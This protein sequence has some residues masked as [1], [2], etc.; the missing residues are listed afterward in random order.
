MYSVKVI[1]NE[2][3]QMLIAI[4]FLIKSIHLIQ[5]ERGKFNPVAR[6]CRLV[7]PKLSS[8][9]IDDCNPRYSL[10]ADAENIEILSSL[11]RQGFLN[12]FKYIILYIL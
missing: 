7:V 3:D 9:L 10:C 5:F 11:H 2:K 4:K 12:V 8:Q 6:S 1:M